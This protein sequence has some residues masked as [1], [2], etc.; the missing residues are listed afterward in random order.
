MPS[1]AP[2]WF[3]RAIEQPAQSHFVDVDGAAIHYLTWNAHET[4][5]PGMLLA[6]G[7]R[8]HARWWSFLAPFFTE[9]F[10]VAALDFAGMGDSAYRS[11]YSSGRYVRDIIG[12]IED[13]KLAPVTLI[14]HSFGGSRVMRAC[15]DYSHLIERA[16]VIDSFIP[17]P[18]LPR[19]GPPPMQPRPKK[20]YPTYEEARARFRLVPEHNCTESYI[21]DYVGHHSMKQTDGGW[22]WKFDELFTP[23]RDDPAVEARQIEAVLQRVNIPVTIV[24]GEKSVV[25][26]PALA[27]AIVSRLPNGRGPVEVPESHHHVLLDQPLALVAALRAALY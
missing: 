4:D 9:R 11:E 19:R 14:G 2:D 12:V 17:L 3:T 5:K 16:V 27:K 10:R 23:H 15:A 7:F 18:E 26:P 8:A 13:A 21:L 20:I 6:H 25:C 24:Y 22:T 1:P